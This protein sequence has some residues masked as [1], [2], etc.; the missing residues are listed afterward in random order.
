MVTSYAKVDLHSS[1]RWLAPELHEH[2][3][4]FTVASDVYALG[5]VIYEV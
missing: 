5:M 3:C 1:A 4:N 2:D